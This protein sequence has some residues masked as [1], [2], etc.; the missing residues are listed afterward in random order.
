MCLGDGMK[1]FI[2]YHMIIGVLYVWKIDL[3]DYVCKYMTVWRND[4]VNQV[5]W[6]LSVF[7]GC[8]GRRHHYSCSWLHTP[9]IKCL[10]GESEARVGGGNQEGSPI[11]Y[12]CPLFV[13][14]ISPFDSNL[15]WSHCLAFMSTGA[16][17]FDVLLP[18]WARQVLLGLISHKHS[19]SCLCSLQS[20]HYYWL[21]LQNSCQHFSVRLC[22][23]TAS[24]RN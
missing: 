4:S 17:S 3:H 16:N 22:I 1:L 6:K 20:R 10:K 12:P 11:T 24:W 18:A 5:V 2:W 19:N 9:P 13:F 14:L 8:G 15:C 21:V 7:T 23:Y